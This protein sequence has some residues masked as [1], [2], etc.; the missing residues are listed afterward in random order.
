MSHLTPW[1]ASAAAAML[2]VLVVAGA[3]GTASAR[4]ATGPYVALGDS[5][6]AAPLV[7]DPTGS[8][9]LCG[10]STGNYP[11][12]VSA[13]IDPSSFTDASCSG[14][15]TDDMT[16]TQTLQAGEANPPQFDA[17][18][19]GDAIVTVGIGGNDADLIGVAEECAQLDAPF[20]FGDRCQSHYQSGA[21]NTAMAAV[22]AIAPRIDATI[23]GIHSRAPQARVLVVGYPDGLPQ[24]ATNCYPTVPFS[25]A[26]VSWFNSLVLELN[27]VLARAA[28]GN[29]ATF[30]DTFSS[31]IGH[32]ACA[33]D[34]WVNGVVPNSSAFPL[35]PNAAGE[36]NMATQVEAAL[37]G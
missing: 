18:D 36:S 29:G 22:D 16:S 33:D 37:G 32:D 12:V 17:L 35:H 15:T 11:H 14:A 2:S 20:P 34:N 4:A 30:V 27:A 25:D 28:Q 21:T 26:D 7:P 6:T 23:Q 9:I 10:R 31:S 3:L 19:A 1:R 5:Y 8:P 13:A 24:N